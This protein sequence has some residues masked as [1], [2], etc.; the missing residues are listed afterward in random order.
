MGVGVPL[1]NSSVATGGLTVHG[2]TLLKEIVTMDKSV[3]VNGSILSNTGKVYIG[4]AL[5]PDGLRVYG[6]TIVSDDIRVD[7]VIV[8][9]AGKVSVGSV[10]EPDGLEV[11]GGADIHDGLETDTLEAGTL[12]AGAT[13]TFVV[14]RED[15][16]QPFSSAQEKARINGNLEVVK[17]VRMQNAVIYWN[18]KVNADL[19]V[20][21]GETT[22]AIIGRAAINNANWGDRATFSHVDK[23]GQTEYALLQN[24]SGQ[25]SVN[26]SKIYLSVD[27]VAKAAVTTAG[28]GIN[29]N[30]PAY[31]L[32]IGGSSA[33]IT[34]VAA[35]SGLA[36]YSMW[37]DSSG[38]HRLKIGVDGVGLNN[39][40]LHTVIGTWTNSTLT[41]AT[42]G[43]RVA[44]MDGAG[45]FKLNNGHT[46]SSDDRVKW[47]EEDIHDGMDTINKLRPQK[48]NK[49]LAMSI[50]DIDKRGLVTES[51]YIAQEV[52][53]IPELDHLVGRQDENSDEL[54]SINM[55]M[56]LPYHT[57]AIQE[58]DLK[59][60]A[61]EQRIRKLEDDN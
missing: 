11:H 37:E 24:N 42:N 16:H 58:L 48:Y 14:P 50:S 38:T 20:I 32:D 47:N 43:V 53:T 18:M 3:L 5:E 9:G 52:G 25:T 21:K 31:K 27:D 61:L 33:G 6:D 44:F 49:S 45:H 60:R 34:R 10:A 57:K 41:F 19:D 12:E 29:N 8:S 1:G 2:G 35:A 55:G 56:L 28:L 7:G 46:V 30:N 59:V 39:Q 15:F 4:S 36:G 22:D 23:L 17:D 51:G 40:N 54:W 13:I 26:G